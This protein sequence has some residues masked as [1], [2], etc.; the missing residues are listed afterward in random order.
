[1]QKITKTQCIDF[2]ENL[3][4]YWPQNFK[5]ILVQKPQNKTFP[6]KIIQVKI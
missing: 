3:K 4:Y 2:L 1:M 5:L 6:K